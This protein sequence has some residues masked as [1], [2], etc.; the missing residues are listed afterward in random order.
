M[1]KN[2]NLYEVQNYN[3]YK[4]EMFPDPGKYP[5]NIVY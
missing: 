5:K 4:M 3:F 1:V 2:A